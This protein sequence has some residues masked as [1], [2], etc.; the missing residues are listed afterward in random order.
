M[1]PSDTLNIYLAAITMG[2]VTLAIRAVI[3]YLI[4]LYKSKTFKPSVIEV[5]DDWYFVRFGMT[6]NEYTHVE[7]SLF[8]GN[9]AIEFTDYDT[10][11]TFLHLVKK[12][13][14]NAKLV[15]I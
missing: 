2:L 1:T 5:T 12:F 11:K 9:K 7:S 4:D 3:D 8:K 14:K 6:L 15:E 13:H 10:A